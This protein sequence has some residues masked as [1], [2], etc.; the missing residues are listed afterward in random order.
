M[1][2]VARCWSGFLKTITFLIIHRFL[3]LKV[4]LLIYLLFKKHCI[5]YISIWKVVLDLVKGTWHHNFMAGCGSLLWA[6]TCSLWSGIKSWPG[7]G[8]Y[9]GWSDVVVS[10]QLR[11]CHMCIIDVMQYILHNTH[12]W[13]LRNIGI[14]VHCIICNFWADHNISHSGILT[15]EITGIIQF[16]SPM[17]L[18]S[19]IARTNSR[20]QHLDLMFRSPVIAVSSIRVTRNF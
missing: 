11:L 6:N 7:Q 17:Y 19:S 15:Y 10:S 20:R 8:V 2:L 9:S 13:I 12:T 4:L 3:S 18:K 1:P 14:L 5:Q 16:S